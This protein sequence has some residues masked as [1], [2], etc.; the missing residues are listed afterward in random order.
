MRLT[1][2]LGRELLAEF[3]AIARQETGPKFAVNGG[4]CSP[5]IVLRRLIR[6]YVVAGAGASV[7]PTSPTAT[8]SRQTASSDEHSSVQREGG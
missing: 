4:D 7:A 6:E 5:P 3:R 8:S 1:L 2:M